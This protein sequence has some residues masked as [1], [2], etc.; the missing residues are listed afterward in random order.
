MRSA[1]GLPREGARSCRVRGWLAT[2]GSSTPR[3]EL[4]AHQTSR[5]R[6]G[7][8]YRVS[9]LRRRL[10]SASEPS[11]GKEFLMIRREG[12]RRSTVVPG[13]ILA[14][15]LVAPVHARNPPAQIGQFAH[16]AWTSR[17]GYSL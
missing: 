11:T 12:Q 8:P 15:M 2:S 16:T 14:S 17:D 9:V 4:A 5:R 13:L 7:S 10:I 1:W 3:D 6:S